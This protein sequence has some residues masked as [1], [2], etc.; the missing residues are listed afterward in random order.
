MKKAIR[1]ELKAGR[2]DKWRIFEVLDQLKKA[3]APNA[4]IEDFVK[5]LTALTVGETGGMIRVFEIEEFLK[6]MGYLESGDAK[7]GL[8]RY[9]YEHYAIE[10]D[11]KSLVVDMKKISNE[12]ELS[13]CLGKVLDRFCVVADVNKIGDAI[14][15]IYEVSMSDEMASRNVNSFG[16]DLRALLLRS[17]EM[18]LSVPYSV[19][20]DY[21]YIDDQLLGI[22]EA[23]GAKFVENSDMKGLD[24]IIE[25]Y[26]RDR[27]E[28]LR[29]SISGSKSVDL[30]TAEDLRAR[31][32]GESVNAKMALKELLDK[33]RSSEGDEVANRFVLERFTKEQVNLLGLKNF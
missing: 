6:I 25:A 31:I 30:K 19:M 17:D 24:E 2:F 7:S 4:E 9:I 20:E 22:A 27:A 8:R 13:A 3:G 5:M 29:N 15:M 21:F 23:Y 11:V 32:Y 14:G 18:Y 28:I 12:K 26:P 1:D 33:I 16:M 10:S